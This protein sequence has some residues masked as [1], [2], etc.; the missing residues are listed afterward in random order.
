MKLSRIVLLFGL[1]LSVSGCVTP[2]LTKDD[3]NLIAV[4]DLEET[5]ADKA[6]GADFWHQTFGARSGVDDRAR[7][8]ERR[9]GF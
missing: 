1:A 9:L 6:P 4:D 8:I 5:S 7:E 3:G 2:S